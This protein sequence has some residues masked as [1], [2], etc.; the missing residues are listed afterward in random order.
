M[1]RDHVSHQAADT[2]GVDGDTRQSPQEQAG[3]GPHVGK[4]RPGVTLIPKLV[5]A[6][7][8]GGRICPS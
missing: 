7:E 6:W 2:S 1:L 5:C 3:S 4:G 8:E